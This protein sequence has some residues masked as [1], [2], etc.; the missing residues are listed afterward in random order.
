MESRVIRN[1]SS[2]ATDGMYINYG[3]TDSVNNAVRFYGAGNA[4]MMRI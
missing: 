1:T 4:E 3:S 2:T